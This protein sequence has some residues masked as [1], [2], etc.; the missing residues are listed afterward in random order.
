M[1]TSEF[2]KNLTYE[3]AKKYNLTEEQFNAFKN[4]K[5]GFIGIRKIK[6]EKGRTQKGFTV[7][8][9]EGISC[10]LE[11]PETWYQTSTVT[12]IDWDKK[13]FTTLNSTYTFEF[14]GTK[15]D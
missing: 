3:D 8:F 6:P 7:A 9:G 13:I 4:S 11:N 15:N 5:E 12:K 10:Y 2:K 14:Y 1:I